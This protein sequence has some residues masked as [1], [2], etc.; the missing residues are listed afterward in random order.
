MNHLNKMN[1]LIKQ[2]ILISLNLQSPQNRMKN[3]KRDRLPLLLNFGL[4]YV[5]LKQFSS[6]NPLL[7]PFFFLITLLLV[8]K[9]RVT[10]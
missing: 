3:R 4:K 6:L 2:R 5:R 10:T 9:V 7:I 8:L 1:K